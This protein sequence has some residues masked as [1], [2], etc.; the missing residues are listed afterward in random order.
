MRGGLFVHHQVNG[1]CRPVEAASCV[2]GTA[3]CSLRVRQKTWALV[4][5]SLSLTFLIF[6]LEKLVINNIHSDLSF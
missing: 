2:Q 5:T 3:V 1:D 6:K 4:P